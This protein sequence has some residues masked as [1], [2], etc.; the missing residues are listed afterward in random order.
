MTQEI[1]MRKSRRLVALLTAAGVTTAL[2]VAGFVAAAPVQAAGTNPPPVQ[3]RNASTV[4][5]D[6][7]PTV[8]IDNGVVWSQAVVGNTVYAG[9]SFSNARPAGAAAG[10]SLIPRQNLLAF[11]ITT[12]VL[13]PNFAPTINGQVKVVRKSPDGSR[14]YIGGSFNTVN[15]TTHYNLAAFDTATGQLITAFKAQVGGSYVNAIAVTND[16]VY[17]GGLISAGNGVSRK[18]L[19][20]FDLTGKLLGWAPTTDLQ[21]DSMVLTPSFSKVIVAGRFSLVNGLAQRGMAALSPVDG[22]TMAWAAPATVQNGSSTGKAGIYSLN[23][24]GNAIYGTGWVFANATVGNLEGTFAADPESGT[25]KWMEDCHGDT[26]DSF[27]DGTNVYTISH[28][29]DCSGVGGF[30]QGSPAPGNLRHAVAFTAAVQGTLTK[31]GVV[32]ST[33]KDWSGQPAPAMINWF[34]DFV[35]GSFTGQGQ[36]AW[37]LGGNG[38]YVVAGGEFPYVNNKLQQGLVRFARTPIAP[39]KDAPVLSGANWPASASSSS[40]GNARIS[41]AQNYDRDDLNL[42]YELRRTGT[43]T[44]IFTTSAASLFWNRPLITVA[45]SGLTPGDTYTYQ[46]SAIDGDGNVTKSAPVSVT[47]STTV[48]AAYPQAVMNDS[49]SHF[50]RLDEPAGTTTGTDW[51]GT[52]DL[53]KAAGATGSTA[54]ALLNESDTATTFSGTS[55]G[56]AGTKALETGPNVFSVAAWFK[57]TSTSGGKIVGFGDSQTGTSN[58]YDRHVYLDNSGHVVFGV[59]NGTTY[60]IASPSTYRDGSWHQVVATLSGNGMV[61]MIDGKKIGANTG[62]TAGQPYSGYW[63]VGGDNLSGWPSAPTSKFLNGS[64][65]E[66]A[67][68]LYALSLSQAQTEYK[69]SGRTLNVAAAPTDNYGKAVYADVPDAYWRLDDANGPTAADTSINASPGVYTNNGVTYRVASPVTGPTGTGAGF[70]GNNGSMGSQQQFVNPKVYSEE[71]WFK[72]TTTAGGKILGFGDKQSGLSTNYDR[73]VYMLTNGRVVFGTNTGVQNLATSASAYN[74][75]NWHH[76]VAAQGADGMHLYLDGQEVATNPQTAAQAFNGFWRVGGDSSWS[77]N[78]YFAG[79]IDE[80]AFYS[81]E[82]SAA[83]VLAHYKASA[84]VVNA[85]PTAAFSSSSTGLTASFDGSG[86]SDPDGSIASYS[87]DFGDNTAAGSGVS[88]QHSYAGGGTYQVKLTVT[89]D[90]GSTNSVT[91]PI[92]VAPLPNK[93]PTAAFSSSSTGSTASFDGTGSSDPDGSIASYSWDFGDG[94]PA[95]SGASPEHAYAL[96]GTY[97]VTLTVTDNDGGTDFVTHPVTV[98]AAP[99]A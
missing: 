15:G 93:L 98:N 35:T 51:A 24:D 23:S 25:I 18:N 46:W 21:V 44:P 99:T 39:A 75:G 81:T 86:S 33:Y 37:S 22:S 77:G 63:R 76:V 83:R 67:V 29:H 6:P 41:I 56:V 78:A 32:N 91:N 74:D 14:I 36:A 62:T 19:M 70:N 43:A 26:Y 16:T 11:D 17:V 69:A 50:W 10:T 94:S 1:T 95:G 45:D 59:Y 2:A 96:S 48:L 84:T 72:T 82:L 89:D 64:I 47:I 61:L 55:N 5:D 49:P 34:P 38:A 53:T 13:N 79:S 54:G 90:Q 28:N 20:A 73:H 65:D 87:W 85:A 31:S 97:Q 7:L 58:N 60:T 30:P 3:Q 42:T 80:V 52:N 4:T 27:S 57:T 92:T 68:Y 66:V 9:G 40:A 88:P 8:Q 71:A 12:G